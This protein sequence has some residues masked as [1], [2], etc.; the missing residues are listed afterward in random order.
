MALILRE[1]SL[2]PG[3][4]DLTCVQE[5]A[6]KLGIPESTIEFVRIV[7]LSL[8]ARRK[9]EIHYNC[10]LRV[11]L[12]SAGDELRILSRADNTVTAE[13]LSKIEPLRQGTLVLPYRPVIIGAGPCGMFAALLL[14]R[15]GYKPIIIERGGPVQER[16]GD[17]ECFFKTGNLN[18]ESNVL[19][20]EGGAG[21][22]SDGK[23]TTRI[24]DPRAEDVLRYLVDFGAP[25]DISYLAK[26][27]IGTDK[28][29]CV[30]AAIRREV[31]RLG[32]EYQFHSRLCG[33]ESDENGLRSVVVENGQRCTI[34]TR[35]CV[36]A[37]GHSARDTY[38]MLFGSG[39]LL[40]PKP[41]AVGVRI[42]HPQSLINE[43]QYG[44][45][46]KDARLGAAEYQLT[47]KAGGRG[48]Y[49][50]CMCPGGEVVASASEEG[51]VVT[52]GMSFHVRSGENANAALIVQVT[53]ADYGLKPLDGVKFQRQM[54]RA[55]YQAG[56]GGF[57]APAQRIIDF[58]AGRASTQFGTVKPTYRPGVTGADLHKLLPSF[59]A[60]GILEALPQFARQLKGFDCADAVMTGV[61]TR[62]SA[63]LRIERDERLQAPSMKGVYPCGEGAGY[64][65]GI[66]SAAVDG[67]RVAQAIVEQFSNERIQSE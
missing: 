8:D 21:T 22:F 12:K 53:P 15:E 56:G 63:P 35:V 67:L 55:A 48:V 50:F 36:L 24:K 25:V 33:F 14:A 1:L 30:V 2:S 34:P 5:S 10:T 16:I 18:K 37:I 57:A 65:G 9:T 52:N 61:E 38:E 43:A 3:F 51:G 49:T 39:F 20:G 23:L 28:L 13:I 26:P 62:S 59:V 29:R 46:S 66:V 47:A 17:V 40:L 44:A 7:R 19:F 58:K 64:A 32:G 31:E 45:L 4:T 60:N 6:H 41:F 54:E 42:E 11:Q 27:H